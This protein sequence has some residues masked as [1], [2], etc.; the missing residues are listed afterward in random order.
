MIKK[1]NI[2]FNITLTKE[3]YKWL[4]KICKQKQISKSNFIKWMLSRKINEIIQYLEL[5]KYTQEELNKLFEIA[6]TNVFDILNI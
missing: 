3:Q 4:Q 5:P 1:D 6:K 2:R